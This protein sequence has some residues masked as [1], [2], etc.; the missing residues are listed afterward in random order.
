MPE[1][2]AAAKKRQQKANRAAGIGDD[3]GRM[4]RVK[5]A[6]TLIKCTVCQQEMKIT[7]TNTEPSA[8]ATSKHSITLEEC[9]PGAT[10][11][12]AELVASTAKGGKVTGGA[13]G[14]T[15]AEAKA[16]A[17]AGFDDLLSA[18]LSGGKKK[19]AKGKK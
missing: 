7:K 5:D 1:S 4:V 9:F 14:I 12:A 18:G 6:P 3:Q 8:H 17:A 19:G 11:A 2:N 16:K 10:E 15:K 13:G